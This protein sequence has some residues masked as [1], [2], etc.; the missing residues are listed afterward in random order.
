MLF[1]K[2]RSVIPLVLS[3]VTANCPTSGKTP[4]GQSIRLTISGTNQKADIVCPCGFPWASFQV[5]ASQHRP[6]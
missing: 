4:N 6:I 1:M 2:W 3:F 5:N